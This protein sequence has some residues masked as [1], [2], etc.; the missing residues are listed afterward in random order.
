MRYIIIILIISSISCSNSSNDSIDKKKDSSTIINVDLNNV[1]DS[2]KMSDYFSEIEYVQLKSSDN[3]PIGRIRKIIP[4]KD[5]IAFYDQARQSVWLFTY[6]G[7]YINE[8]IIPEGR[9][10]GEIIHMSD[11]IISDDE[12]IHALGAYKIVEY[13]L[14]GNLQNEVNFKFFIYKIAYNSSTNEYI[15]Y[16]DNSINLDLPDEHERKNLIFF[17]KEGKITQSFLPI[18]E[19]REQMGFK[20]PNNFPSYGTQIMFSPHMVDTVYKLQEL[21]VTAKYVLDFGEHAIPESAFEKR[22][23]YSEGLF[24]WVE[25][26]REELVGK[27]Y[28]TFLRFFNETNSHLFFNMS[29]GNN[30]YN[31]LYDKFKGKAKVGPQKLSNDIDY[32]FVPFMY[33]SDDTALYAIIETNELLRHLNKVYNETPEIYQNPKMKELIDLAHSLPQNGN[34]ILQILRFKE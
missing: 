3:R 9:G 12:R 16:A 27:N 22:K 11:V 14:E 20:I 13:D 17:N 24:D 19:G 25:F 31:V 34:P 7:E 29:T 5:R 33:E 2:L 1:E 15:G 30:Q 18:K 28:V 4:L 8:I 26:Q 6:D 32:G 23:E 21:G 10:P